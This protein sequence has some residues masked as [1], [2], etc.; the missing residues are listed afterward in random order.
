MVAPRN[1]IWHTPKYISKCCRSCF[2]LFGWGLHKELF[3]IISRW[4]GFPCSSACPCNGTDSHVSRQA[5]PYWLDKLSRI[6][7]DRR[8]YMKRNSFV[9]FTLFCEFFSRFF[10][11]FLLFLNIIWNYNFGWNVVWV[12]CG[13]G[14]TW[15]GWN[16]VWVKCYWVKFYR[17][18][19]YWVKCSR[20]H[21]GSWIIKF[22]LV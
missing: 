3:H 17:V 9:N 7:F 15:F 12:K 5:D 11:G 10:R 13:L 18:K 14:E 1:C 16:V 19:C 20:S 21:N 6:Y 22:N 2:L 8:D 4:M